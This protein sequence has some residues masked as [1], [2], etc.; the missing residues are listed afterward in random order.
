LLD[1]AISPSVLSAFTVAE[2]Y[3]RRILGQISIISSLLLSP[4]R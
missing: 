4:V 3:C 1:I 2:K